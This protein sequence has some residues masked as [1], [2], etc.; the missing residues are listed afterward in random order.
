MQLSCRNRFAARIAGC[1]QLTF[2]RDGWGVV[3]VGEPWRVETDYQLKSLAVHVHKDMIAFFCS[4]LWGFSG[5]YLCFLCLY[6]CSW[7]VVF[8]MIFPQEKVSSTH[9]RVCLALTILSNIVCTGAVT[10]LICTNESSCWLDS[11]SVPVAGTEPISAEDIQAKVTPHASHSLWL[12]N[13]G[14]KQWTMNCLTVC[15]V[16]ILF[17]GLFLLTSSWIF[18]LLYI[19]FVVPHS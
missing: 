14:F 17:S 15:F 1:L 12:S 11:R 2:H 5:V 13:V 9:T 3:C 6:R 10:V 18:L 4:G 19:V 8:L 16:H 7:L